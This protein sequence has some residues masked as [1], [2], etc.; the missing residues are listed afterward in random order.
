M[1]GLTAGVRRTGRGEQGVDLIGQHVCEARVEVVDG[2]LHGLHPQT[3][4]VRLALQQ[5][6]LLV[7]V[8]EALRALLRRNALP[9]GG[10]VIHVARAV[11]IA[12]LLAEDDPIRYRKSA[13]H[14]SVQ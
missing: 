4:R 14:K 5:H 9:L 12:T 6:V 2:L 11:S 8:A 3:Q 10:G 1:N 13:L 7:E